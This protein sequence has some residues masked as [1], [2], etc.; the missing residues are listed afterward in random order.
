MTIH[1]FEKT[2]QKQESL[3]AKQAR[4]AKRKAAQSATSSA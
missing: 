1:A 2:I 3:E 4:Q